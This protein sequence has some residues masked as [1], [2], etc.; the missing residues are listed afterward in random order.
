MLVFLLPGSIGRVML[1]GTDIP[2]GRAD[3]SMPFC[4][5]CGARLAEGSKFC[6]DCGA[7]VLELPESGE[8]LPTAPSSPGH[9]VVA[10]RMVAIIPNL[11]RPRRLS[12]KGPVWHHLV[13]TS[14]RIMVVQ[15]TVTGLERFKQ[16]IGVIGPDPGHFS[17]KTMKPERILEEN[18]ESQVIPLTDLL[19]L[20]VTKFV[21][22]STEDGTEPYWQVQLTT[23]KETLKLV[24]DYHDD[25]GE[26]FQDP[27]LREVLGERLII[28]DM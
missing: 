11:I 23:R 26:Y 2:V 3:R 24:T 15:R 6:T 21:F 12:L 27:A 28:Q 7:A 19:S 18:P 16:D 1:P 17:L 5:D 9:P 22:Y 25:P 14:D 20:A 10:E 13:V 4:Q 8:V